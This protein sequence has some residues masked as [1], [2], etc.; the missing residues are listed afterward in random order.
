[1]N[2]LEKLSHVVDRQLGDFECG[3]V[4]SVIE[5]RPAHDI[6]FAFGPAPD[7]DILSQ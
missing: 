2:R 3:E 1:L 5:L 4:P 6:V 7:G